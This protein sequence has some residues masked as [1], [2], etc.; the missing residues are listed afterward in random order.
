MSLIEIHNHQS[1]DQTKQTKKLFTQRHYNW[2]SVDWMRNI[3]S[4]FTV[5]E[6][7][8]VS[9]FT[10]PFN[11]LQAL[12]FGLSRRAP[13]GYKKQCGSGTIGYWH[14][15][16]TSIFCWNDKSCVPLASASLRACFDLFFLRKLTVVKLLT[17]T[18]RMG[19][20]SPWVSYWHSE[21]KASLCLFPSFKHNLA[22]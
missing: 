7:C 16:E 8:C 21:T 6:F 5:L 15:V 22:S 3:P 1:I 13:F 4:A 18:L 17:C 2:D 11:I 9:V 20:S 12:D 19:F 14:T 10:I